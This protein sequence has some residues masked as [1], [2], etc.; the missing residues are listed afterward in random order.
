MF[1]ELDSL[2]NIMTPPEDSPYRPEVVYQKVEN[3]Q[4]D[5]QHG[6][7]ELCLETH[8]H[9]HTRYKTQGGHND[10]PYAPLATE[11]KANEQEYQEDSPCKLEVHFTILLLDFWQASERLGFSNP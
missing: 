6:R 7:T 2:A 10:P 3:T 11:N 5:N 4:D 1:V 9:H 8:Y